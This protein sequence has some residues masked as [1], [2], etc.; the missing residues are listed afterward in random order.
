MDIAKVVDDSAVCNV[1]QLVSDETGIVVPT[2]DWTSFFAPRM[3]KFRVLKVPSFS[4]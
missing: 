2:R 3:K 4:F 1:S